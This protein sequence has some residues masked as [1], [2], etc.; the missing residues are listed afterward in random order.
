MATAAIFLGSYVKIAQGGAE[1]LTPE[2]L[3]VFK[4][5]S[6]YTLKHDEE[7]CIKCGSCEKQ[8]PLFAITMDEET[9]FP[10]VNGTC[11]RCGQC[12]T[13][14]PVGARTLHLKEEVLELPRRCWMTTTRRACTVSRTI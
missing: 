8:C 1:P 4:Y 10:T 14:C 9:G 13:V 3:N 11:V 12:G 6:H 5:L 7:S 2:D